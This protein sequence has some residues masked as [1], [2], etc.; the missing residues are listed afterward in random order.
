[1]IVDVKLD[2]HVIEG[3]DVAVIRFPSKMRT[4]GSAILGGGLSMADTAVIM[5]V[6]KNYTDDAPEKRLEEVCSQLGLDGDVVGF[7]TA[8]HVKKVISVSRE[9]VNGTEAVVV[10]TAGLSNAVVAGELLPMYTL[11]DSFEGGTINIVAIVNEPLNDAAMANAFIPITEA[12]TVAIQDVGANATGTTSDAIVV[13][14]PTGGGVKYA[15]TATKVGV[16]LARATRKAVLECLTKNGDGPRPTDYLMRLEE[17]G[18]TVDD[19]WHAAEELYFPNPEWDIGILKGMFEVRLNAMRADV[20][21]NALVLS[22]IAMDERGEAGRLYGLPRDQFLEDPVHLLA[23]EMIAMALA[24][25][26]SGTKGLFEYTRYDRKKPGILADLPPFLDDV[27]AALIG[28][29]M[30][31]I[32]TRLLEGE[33]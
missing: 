10:A 8:A 3:G 25:Y 30:S 14:C 21:V 16:A 24:Q 22:A 11:A 17:R 28:G 29:V 7:M 20:N 15:G 27:V 13:A 23:D 1:M 12:K 9:E 33:K 26:I 19:M 18:V 4:L 2:F 32:Y 5:Q 6:P 31:D